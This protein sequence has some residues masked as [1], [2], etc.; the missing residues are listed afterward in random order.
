M[1]YSFLPRHFFTYIPNPHL[2]LTHILLSRLSSLSFLFPPS[3]CVVMEGNTTVDNMKPARSHLRPQ[4]LNH[5]NINN[6]DLSSETILII[7][8]AV[9]SGLVLMV[10]IILIIFMFRRLKYCPPKNDNRNSCTTHD[11]TS[12]RF[13]ASATMNLGSSPGSLTNLY[14]HMCVY[15]IKLIKNVI[16]LREHL[17]RRL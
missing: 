5:N 7:V 8:V 13:L 15:A 4:K 6:P 2:F 1:L 17:T 3:V 12:C 9:A 14:I 16:F 10:I 11:E